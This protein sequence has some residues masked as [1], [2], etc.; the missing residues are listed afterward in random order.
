M[1]ERKAPHPATRNIREYLGARLKNQLPARPGISRNTTDKTVL[2][3]PNLDELDLVRGSKYIMRKYVK[4]VNFIKY[5]SSGNLIRAMKEFN[6]KLTGKFPYYGPPTII[7]GGLYFFIAGLYSYDTNQNY[8]DVL[9]KVVSPIVQGG[10]YFIMYPFILYMVIYSLII[11]F[12]SL[13]LVKRAAAWMWAN[14]DTEL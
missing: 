2:A 11:L 4:L 7:I 8:F 10:I 13:Y 6:R 3:E 12:E 9:F 5:V 1:I 14:L